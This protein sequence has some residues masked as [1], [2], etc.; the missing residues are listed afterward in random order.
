M[1]KKNLK[2]LIYICLVIILSS[3]LTCC[4]SSNTSVNANSGIL[5]SGS[6]IDAENKTMTI[7]YWDK[8]GF[9]TMWDKFKENRKHIGLN[10]VDV[11]S[12]DYLQKI[13]TSLASG[14]E[15]PDLLLG[16][17]AYRGKLL[18]LNI[19]EDLDSSPY[20][21]ARTKLEDYMIPLDINPRGQ[22]CGIDNTM[23]PAGI[24]YKADLASK[25]LGTDDPVK[26]QQMLPDWNSFI[27][28]GKEV[29]RLSKG[30]VYM[31]PGQM[32][33]LTMLVAQSPEPLID[34]SKAI[35][36]GKVFGNSFSILVKMR[37]AGV[38]DKLNTWSPEWNASFKQNNDIFYPCASWGPQ[39][40]IK[41]NDRDSKG[42]WRIMAAP[43][44][45]YN[46]GGTIWGIYNKSRIKD[47]VWEYIKWSIFGDGAV[48]YREKLGYFVPRKD[49]YGQNGYDLSKTSDPYFGGQNTDEL[50]YGIIMKN[51]KVR[52]VTQYDQQFKEVQE[53]I[54][55]A[56]ELD[57]GLTAETAL[58]LFK[59]ELKNKIPELQIDS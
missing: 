36:I 27:V 14:I 45:G 55:N 18:T 48:I 19:W 25:Y 33:A 52:P 7:W 28:Y 43:G 44:G 42:R 57:R 31:L 6:T 50:F 40:I 54:G 11:N 56:I 1:S 5:P 21:A 9:M 29:N 10:Y 47:D 4:S 22:L 38:L 37:D 49:L 16:E 39:Y 12:I 26:L 24:A 8:E 13:Q 34:G 3:I 30:K 20:N 32:D 23:C 46:Y 15:L 17:M 59:Q 41:V 51:L 53:L 58:K 2:L 35:N